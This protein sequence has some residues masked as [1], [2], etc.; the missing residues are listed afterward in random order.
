MK[1]ATGVETQPLN[2][3]D[4]SIQKQK[5]TEVVPVRLQQ[6]LRQLLQSQR[7]F[8]GEGLSINDHKDLDQRVLKANETRN[9]FAIG[10]DI[11]SCSLGGRKKMPKNAGLGLAMKTITWRKENITML[12]HHGPCI[13]Y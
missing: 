1:G 12:N 7:A 6:L 5:T 9:I 4:L 10:Q 8:K 3:S 11:A 13:S 2:V